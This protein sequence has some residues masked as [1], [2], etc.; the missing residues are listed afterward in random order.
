M[1]WSQ[2]AI[3]K[4]DCPAVQRRGTRARGTNAAV[5]A[6][7]RRNSRREAI[8]S[9]S[10]VRRLEW[11]IPPPAKLTPAGGW[12]GDSNSRSLLLRCFGRLNHRRR[13]TAELPGVLQAVEVL[14]EARIDGLS[15]RE[16]NVVQEG[17]GCDGPGR[18]IGHG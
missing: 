7:N 10:R 14:Q 9:P 15:I 18:G 16:G 8:F 5:E 4:V 13:R 11:T 17:I 1:K 12:K 6:I 3:F 2:R